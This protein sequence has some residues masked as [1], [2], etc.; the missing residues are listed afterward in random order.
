MGN[1]PDYH[2]IHMSLMNIQHLCACYNRVWVWDDSAFLAYYTT[3][4]ELGDPQRMAGMS[5][6]SALFEGERTL[7][8]YTVVLLRQTSQRRWEPSMLQVTATITNF[9]LNLHPIR[10]KYSR[11]TLP[12]NYIQSVEQTRA[13]GYNCVRLTLRTGQYLYLMLSTGQLTHLY[14]DLCAMTAPPPRFQFDARIPSDSIYRLIE[15]FDAV[16]QADAEPVD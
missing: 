3:I 7:G 15:F 9:R 11:A 14:E 1:S 16:S 13:N 12:C 10:K 5:E 8:R 4:S 2:I 6:Q